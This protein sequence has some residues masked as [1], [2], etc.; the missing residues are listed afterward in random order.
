MRNDPIMPAHTAATAL[1][2]AVVAFTVATAAC[3][4]ADAPDALGRAA[5]A[6][7]NR[8]T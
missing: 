7:T 1:A 8:R 5:L 4:R 3:P 2:L 6:A